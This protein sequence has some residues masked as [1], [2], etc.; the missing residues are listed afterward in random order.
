[1]LLNYT[2]SKVE[3][4]SAHL[5]HNVDIEVLIFA[6]FTIFCFL[7]HAL[8]TKSHLQAPTFTI[9]CVP[10]HCSGTLVKERKKL[11]CQIT[12]IRYT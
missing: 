6:L 11:S 5:I 2:T 10:D 8:Y 7:F 1:M 12:T 4:F 3:I 9:F